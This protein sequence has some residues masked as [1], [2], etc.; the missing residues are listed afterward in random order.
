MDD[1]SPSPNGVS[2]VPEDDLVSPEIPV[3]SGSSSQ[4]IRPTTLDNP[5]TFLE[6]RS[7]TDPLVIQPDVVTLAGVISCASPLSH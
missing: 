4:T 6:R 1:D 3:V 5:G 7:K 2:D